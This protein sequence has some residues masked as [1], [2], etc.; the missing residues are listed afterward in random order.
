L[1]FLAAQIFALVDGVMT[2]QAQRSDQIVISFDPTALAA[3][4]VCVRCLHHMPR[5]AVFAFKACHQFQQLF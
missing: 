3:A 2:P 4:P 5:P 1:P